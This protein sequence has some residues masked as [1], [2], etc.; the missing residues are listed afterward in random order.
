MKHGTER[1]AIVGLGLL[2]TSLA[3]ALKK[4]G[5]RH[6]A[7]WTRNAQVRGELLEKGVLDSSAE[8]VESV[9]G[10]ADISVLCM[11][12]AQIAEFCQ[13]HAKSFKRGSTV[14]DVGSV[15]RLIMDK[16]APAIAA[17]GSVFV[18]G[19]P[20]A[21]SEKSGPDAAKEDLFRGAA[22]FLT[23]ASE[24]DGGAVS[25][26]R[27]LWKSVGGR[28]I[29]AGASEHDELI[30][31]SS[32]LPHAIA[33]SLALTALDVPEGRKTI[34]QMACASSF[35]DMTRVAG[36][37]PELWTGIFEANKD[38]LLSGIEQFKGRLDEMRAL[39]ESG[40]FKSLGAMMERG[41]SL[42]EEWASARNHSSK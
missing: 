39:L 14:S 32:H 5:G 22:V 19:H 10:S 30:A 42:R 18:G 29:E 7:G 23:P 38:A 31:K 11:P 34:A 12:V 13:R 3:L 1:V 27:E 41:K 40:D 35:R 2:G 28:V 4:A 24:A 33:W 17:A 21:G 20:M 16:A 26:L 15:K 36:S 8:D 25:A 37:S 6:V 9:I